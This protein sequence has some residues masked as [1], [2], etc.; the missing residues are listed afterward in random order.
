M[1]TRP[2]TGTADDIYREPG[3]G[4]IVAVAVAVA[5]NLCGAS[6]RPVTHVMADAQGLAD[7][8]NPPFT[9]SLAGLNAE[10]WREIEGKLDAVDGGAESPP[11]DHVG[12]GQQ[13]VIAVVPSPEEQ[14]D[15]E[16]ESV[17][18]SMWS[19]VH[20]VTTLAAS[21]AM[22]CMAH[23]IPGG[24]ADAD[25]DDEDAGGHAG[26]GG[27]R[28]RMSAKA[29]QAVKNAFFE[30]I[31]NHEMIESQWCDDWH[32]RLAV[33]FLVQ[34]DARL[35]LVV[36]INAP[37]WSIDLA[38][39]RYIAHEPLR[40]ITPEGHMVLPGKHHPRLGAWEALAFTRMRAELGLPP[41][42]KMIQHNEAIG[43]SNMD[44]PLWKRGLAVRVMR[45]PDGRHPRLP[46][47]N[48]LEQIFTV[49]EHD[50]TLLVFAHPRH[51]FCPIQWGMH[52]KSALRSGMFWYFMRYV[53]PS[54]PPRQ[55]SIPE[56]QWAAW[57][58]AHAETV[59]RLYRN[60]CDPKGA[61]TEEGVSTQLERAQENAARGL[62]RSDDAVLY[63]IKDLTRDPKGPEVRREAH[64]RRLAAA[65]MK[66]HAKGPDPTFAVPPDLGPDLPDDARL[67]IHLNDSLA[68]CEGVVT[69]NL[70]YGI[71]LSVCTAATQAAGDFMRG[72]GSRHTFFFGPRATGKTWIL[73]V[74]AAIFGKTFVRSRDFQSA[75]SMLV[76]QLA[77]EDKNPF[78]YTLYIQ[79]E[80]TIV[81]EKMLDMMKSMIS[82]GSEGYYYERCVKK[83]GGGGFQQEKVRVGVTGIGT[84]SSGNWKKPSGQVHDQEGAYE[85]RIMCCHM[86]L[87][88]S[89]YDNR[90]YNG[91]DP[92]TQRRQAGF[93][94]AMRRM[95]HFFFQITLTGH[96]L[97]QK[98]PYRPYRI[99]TVA[100][101]TFVRDLAKELEGTHGITLETRDQNRLTMY[102]TV[103][104]YL[105][106]IWKCEHPT[107]GT[108]P[109]DPLDVF[110]REGF[111]APS[112]PLMV[113][114]ASLI[115]HAADLFNKEKD[116]PLVAQ[117]ILDWGQELARTTFD[118]VDVASYVLIPMHTKSGSPVDDFVRRLTVR[119][120][121]AGDMRNGSD[122]IHQ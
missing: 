110:V 91:E 22:G 12:D 108:A 40:K 85:S 5:P 107:D 77:H 15:M 118:N 67:W 1:R 88:G 74:T 55:A 50:P 34:H 28:R 49:D 6:V 94:R 73:R 119:T 57:R 48:G 18:S 104:S 106:H 4:S 31:Q 25:E 66:N 70:P 35:L 14:S 26:G 90:F 103:A 53:G 116:G 97:F 62:L 11:F 23:D 105:A 81:D 43:G 93:R 9:L 68:T 79:D 38:Y 2:P 83:K 16:D 20:F 102:I 101:D 61:E 51:V 41:P 92:A 109:R 84:A 21:P 7:P 117:T 37:R 99:S 112:L 71:I 63:T 46:P 13:V 59:G 100:A 64:L 29:R 33:P 95:L 58:Q 114:M 42:K 36:V 27:G 98:S 54:M 24:D 86:K 52:L 32:V 44:S 3:G 56:H 78:E 121:A 39:E 96:A 80:H 76:P 87:L 10:S 17:P 8:D 113:W 82:A 60:A 30:R 120:G 111:P 89:H 19:W 122:R 75:K 72:R 69:Q 47:I 65:W 115:V 45:D